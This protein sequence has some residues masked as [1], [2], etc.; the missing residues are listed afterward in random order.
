MTAA[1]DIRPSHADLNALFAC[2]P[3]T[4][5]TRRAVIDALEGAALLR[6]GTPPLA[7]DPKGRLLVGEVN[8]ALGKF[9]VSTRTQVMA[10]LS[11]VG[12]LA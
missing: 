3:M 12:A 11:S 5:E 7:T 2:T 8:R 1:S 4:V 9:D 10:V 6:G